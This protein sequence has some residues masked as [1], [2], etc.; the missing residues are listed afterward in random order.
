MTGR[1]G[2]TDMRQGHHSRPLVHDT[3]EHEQ[4]LES[5]AQ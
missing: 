2:T 3:K 5:F 1:V 4:P